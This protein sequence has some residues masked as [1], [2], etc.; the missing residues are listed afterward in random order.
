MDDLGIRWWD[1]L[2]LATSPGEGLGRMDGGGDEGG[3]DHPP[4]P[5][6]GRANIRQRWR[7][8]PA[9]ASPAPGDEEPS[10]TPSG[11]NAAL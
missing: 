7:T 5:D 2:R 6:R 1:T 3:D 9:L 10:A 4:G 8:L 11:R